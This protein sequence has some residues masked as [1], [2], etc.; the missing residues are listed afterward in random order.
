[1]IRKSGRIQPNKKRQWTIMKKTILAMAVPSL[2][3]A[4]SAFAGVNLYAD[5][6]VTVDV[7]G[8]AEVQYYKAGEKDSEDQI[9][10]DDG[11]LAFDINVEVSDSL[12]AVAGIGFAFE[13]TY[14]DETSVLNDELYVGFAGDWGTFTFG[15]QLLINDDLGNTKDI[16]FGGDTLG[17]G[18]S[19]SSQALKYVFDN[20]Q[21]Y[22]AASASIKEDDDQTATGVTDET[23][24][25]DGRLGARF[26][27][28]DARVYLF[29]GSDLVN[30]DGAVHDQTGYNLEVDY[31]F[32]DW[33]V[34]GSYGN[35]ENEFVGGGKDDVDVISVSADYTMNM[36][37]FAGGYTLA[38]P[39]TSNSDTSSIFFNV[40]QKL[41]SN[42][43]AYGE[44]AFLDADQDT[45]DDVA[46]VVGMEVSF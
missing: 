34:A 40:T 10:L 4:G 38:S 29:S 37:T 1:M 17:F 19:Q 3:A 42:V 31:V 9:R 45:V 35:V 25:V 8:A 5:N 43:K 14:N 21:F 33:S 12:S 13:D 18:V 44:L 20:G 15:R 32:G 30:S 28:L 24:V 11:D 7:S 2:L 6:G 46:Y 26:G 36:T 22:A 16:E 41:H 23:Q 27:D 39:S